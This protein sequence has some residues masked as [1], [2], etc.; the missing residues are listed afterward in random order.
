MIRKALVE[1]TGSLR[2]PYGPHLVLDSF[3][4]Q[5]AALRV[6]Q[7]DSRELE[8]LRHVTYFKYII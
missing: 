1:M 6:L 5:V 8:D 7:E 3:Y 4:H 2:E